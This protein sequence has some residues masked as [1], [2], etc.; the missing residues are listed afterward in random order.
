VDK[1]VF[2]YNAALLSNK[3]N[4]LIIPQNMNTFENNCAKSNKPNQKMGVKYYYKT[5]AGRGGV[6]L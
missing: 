3:K 1:S 4:A 5:L 6:H 2:S